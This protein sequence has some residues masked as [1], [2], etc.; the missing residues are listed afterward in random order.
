MKMLVTP[1]L[2]ARHE[3][4]VGGREGYFNNFNYSIFENDYEKV[5]VFLDNGVHSISHDS[6]YAILTREEHL[7]LGARRAVELGKQ[8]AQRAFR[9]T[10]F[11]Y[12]LDAARNDANFDYVWARAGEG[13]GIGGLLGTIGGAA[14]GARL[15]GLEGAAVGALLSGERTDGVDGDQAAN[16]GPL[17]LPTRRAELGARLDLT[18]R[19]Q[20]GLRID[21]IATD[22]PAQAA[23]LMA[24]DVITSIAGIRVN[25]RGSF[26][27]A[28]ERAFDLQN[29]EVTFWRDGTEQ[30]LQFDPSA[31]VLAEEKQ[32]AP[33]TADSDAETGR[34]S[35]RDTE[36][37]LAELERLADL[38]DRGI[39]SEEEFEAMKARILEGT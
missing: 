2:I 15:G 5:R 38:H 25:S 18:P 3:I 23:G 27:V 16:G 13:G 28:T 17:P 12:L 34:G 32:E 30:A 36:A 9:D 7:F 11:G 20:G 14:L 8:H 37:M 39:L 31:S 19:P 4:E 22:G 35:A 1:D 6:D 21:S 24:G 29:F 26:Y 33:A 10:G